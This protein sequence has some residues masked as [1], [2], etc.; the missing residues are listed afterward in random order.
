MA[1][2]IAAATAFGKESVNFAFKGV[3]ILFDGTMYVRRVGPLFT[4]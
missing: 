4:V 2:A 1:A 3:L